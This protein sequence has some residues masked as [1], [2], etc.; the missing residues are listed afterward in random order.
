MVQLNVF[1]NH[2][3]F[4]VWFLEIEFFWRQNRVLN[5]LKVKLS[6]QDL[7]I[8]IITY[9]PASNNDGFILNNYTVL[10]DYLVIFNLITRIVHIETI[11]GGTLK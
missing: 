4:I 3:I 2:T 9:S 6:I 8:I 10:G 5:L 11:I 1:L 7:N